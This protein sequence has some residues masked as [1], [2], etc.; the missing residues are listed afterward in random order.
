MPKFNILHSNGKKL[1]QS[2]WPLWLPYPTCWLKSLIL[3]V[4]LRFI[5]YIAEMIVKTGYRVAHFA[6]SLELVILF[7]IITIVSPIP[8]IAFTH[9]LLHLFLSRFISEA[10][11]PEIGNTKGLLPKLMSWW[12]GLYGWL[13]IILSTLISAFFCT[14]LLP[15]F[16]DNYLK[17]IEDYTNFD[18]NIVVIF[19]IIWLIQAAFIYQ[20][21]YLVRHRFISVYSKVKEG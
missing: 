10:Q 13:V 8:I 11:A 19:G 21:E 17:N 5:T 9:H 14:L 12:E 6:N 2:R 7:T 16:K 1:Q 3:A 18:Q 20:V 4:F 15:F